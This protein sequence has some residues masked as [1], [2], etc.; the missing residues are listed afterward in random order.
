MKG[1]H[2]VVHPWLVDLLSW[3]SVRQF[4]GFKLNGRVRPPPDPDLSPVTYSIFKLQK[5]GWKTG[6][7]HLYLFHSA[8]PIQPQ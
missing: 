5:N 2:S 3:A 6:C 8:I 1:E 7:F 4:H